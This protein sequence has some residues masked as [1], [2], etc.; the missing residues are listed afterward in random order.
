MKQINLAHFDA[1]RIAALDAAM[2]RSYYN[3][4]FILLFL[5]LIQLL[6]VQFGFSWPTT[7]RLAYHAGWAAAYYRINKHR[8][9]D[10]TRVLKNLTKFYQL[11]AARATRPFDYQKAA[12]LELAWWD[13]HRGSTTN[14]EALEQSLADGAA[15]IYN[16]APDRL[17][18]YAHYRAE[19]MILPRHEGDATHDTPTDWP[20]IT[21]MLEIAWH[22]L[23]ATINESAA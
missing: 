13:I 18:A 9:V 1:S 12:E 6:K 11:I 19:A 20:K 5:Q 21:T 7:L 15:A 3:H 23:H 22:A 10:N 16:V 4:R 8:S 14:N 17:T 2:W